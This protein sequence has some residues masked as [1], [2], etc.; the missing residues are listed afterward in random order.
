MVSINH[1]TGTWDLFNKNEKRRSDST[2]H[3]LNACKNILVVV[4]VVDRLLCKTVLRALNFEWA[5]QATTCHV[6]DV[7][8]KKKFVTNYS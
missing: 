5:I 3:N 7:M 2:Y 8:E 6:V 1:F 4:Q